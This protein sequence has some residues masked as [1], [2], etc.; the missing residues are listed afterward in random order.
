ML[1]KTA[2]LKKVQDSTTSIGSYTTV[3]SYDNLVLNGS[4]VDPFTNNVS[5][6]NN[7][8][9]SACSITS[10]N[11][12][13]FI[14]FTISGTFNNKEITEQIQGPTPIADSATTSNL[15]DT[16]TG[17]KAF[18]QKYPLNAAFDLGSN[19]DSIVVLESNANE[20]CTILI[21]SPTA[22][23]NWNPT[24]AVAY[25]SID[26]TV[27]HTRQELDFGLRS[28][29]LVSLLDS[30]N[31]SVNRLQSGSINV[32]AHPFKAIIVAL[33]EDVVDSDVLIEITQ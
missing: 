21:N 13:S 15:F 26:G 1:K 25:G 24:H 23:T 31:L 19:R 3:G 11:D 18:S 27:P 12:T 16:I 30:N 28:D 5:F 33:T 29:N 14:T 7:G 4:L 6:I 8:Y 2:K 10:A 17:V 9:A 32:I 22:T 20:N